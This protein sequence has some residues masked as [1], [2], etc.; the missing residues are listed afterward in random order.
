MAYELIQQNMP[1]AMPSIRTIQSAIHL[2]YKTISF[3]F[4]EL[5]GHL[6][7]YNAP[8][9][10]SIAE[11]AT[12]I[13][14]WIEYDSETDRCVGFVLSLDQNGLPKADSIL[15]VLFSAIEAMFQNNPIAK[16]TYVYMVQPLSSN[17]APFCLACTG[18]IIN[19]LH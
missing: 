19:L 1:E 9:F 2:E 11:N 16:F 7:Q 12:R 15:A 17:S 18:Q 13:V 4:D 5:I 14:G 6:D 8:S 3:R 10:I